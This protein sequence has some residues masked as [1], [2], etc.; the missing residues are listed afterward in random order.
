MNP[1]SEVRE[2][3][4]LLSD[5]V[6]YERAIEFARQHEPVDA[7]QLNGLLQYAQEWHDLTSFVDKQ[8]KRDWPQT[9]RTRHYKEFYDDLHEALRQLER[10]AAEFVPA[11]LSRHE[12]QAQ[13]ALYAG[14]LAREFVQHQVAEAQFAQTVGR[15]EQ[16]G[17]APMSQRHQRR[18]R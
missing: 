15:R 2:R 13:T 5:G 1:S 11:G 6:L 12:Q 17:A 18:E 10:D 3:I 7:A 14:L 8:R 4:G 9:G 16:P